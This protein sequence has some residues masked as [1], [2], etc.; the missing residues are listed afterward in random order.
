M[1]WISTILGKI[2][3]RF[4]N[5]WEKLAGKSIDKNG[6]VESLYADITC[7]QMKRG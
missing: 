5:N 1:N 2:K 7:V 3:G 6:S 4:M